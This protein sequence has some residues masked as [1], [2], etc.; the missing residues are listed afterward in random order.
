MLTVGRHGSG[1]TSSIRGALAGSLIVGTSN[2]EFMRAVFGEVGEHRPVVVSFRGNPIEARAGAWSGTAW[3]GDEKSRELPVTDNN[4]F[5]VATFKPDGDGR[6][7]RRKS[8]FHDL[9]AIV[10]DDVGTKV[11]LDRLTALPPS[12]LVET[13]QRNFQAG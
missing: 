3:R 13:S 10:L 7:R 12:W 4:Y 1:I 5:S 11:P 9:R 6:Y 2:D 8:S